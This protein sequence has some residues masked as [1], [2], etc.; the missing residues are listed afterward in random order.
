MTITVRGHWTNT[1]KPGRRLVHPIGLSIAHHF[2][3]P[4]I[5]G[6]TTMEREAQILRNVDRAHHDLGYGGLGYNFVIFD[7]GRIW[8]ARGWSK[9]GAHT[10]GQNSRS[11]GVCWAINGDKAEPSKKGWDA[12]FILLMH[13]LRARVIHKDFV[14]SQHRRYASKSCPGY[15]ISDV[16]LRNMEKWTKAV[17]ANELKG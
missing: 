17:Y 4:D 16:E 6:E 7:S 1:P 10:A 9:T 2:Y 13:G 15:Q 12:Y 5:R 11:L 3:R 14:Q 8:E